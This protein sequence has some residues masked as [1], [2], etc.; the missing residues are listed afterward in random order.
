MWRKV[1]DVWDESP[2]SKIVFECKELTKPTSKLLSREGTF[3]SGKKA[4]FWELT[5]ASL[6]NLEILRE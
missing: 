1:D 3:V 6:P 2:V 5:I 4:K